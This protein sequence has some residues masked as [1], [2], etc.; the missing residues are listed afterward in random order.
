MSGGVMGW[1]MKGELKG[2]DQVIITH[3]KAKQMGEY[4]AIRNLYLQIFSLLQQGLRWF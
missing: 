1:G 3:Q 4:R 2:H